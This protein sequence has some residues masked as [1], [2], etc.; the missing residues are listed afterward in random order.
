MPWTVEV[1]H[2]LEHEKQVYSTDL[3]SILVEFGDLPGFDEL[4]FPLLR[5]VDRYGHTYF[6]E[7]QVERGVL[8]EL[9]RFAVL[10]PSA[11]IDALIDVAR[12]VASTSHAF[13]AF[14]GD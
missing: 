5:L 6:N 14:Q 7:Y 3:P 9:L 8:P 4:D 2:Y 10:K 11:R 12:E 1:G 13:L